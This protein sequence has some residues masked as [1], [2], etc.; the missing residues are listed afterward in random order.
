MSHFPE[1]LKKLSI[2][3]QVNCLIQFLQ[4]GLYQAARQ[5]DN[6]AAIFE[7][8]PFP[9][10]IFEFPI[11]EFPIFDFRY[12]ISYFFIF[13]FTIFKCSTFEFSNF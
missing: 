12:Y 4:E 8:P 13:E 2:K 7:F 10:L 9:F 3:D 5:P 6:Q 1:L 11:F